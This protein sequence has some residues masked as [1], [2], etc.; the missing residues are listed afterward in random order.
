MNGV[1]SVIPDEGRDVA[2]I[3][4]QKVMAAGRNPI[5]EFTVSAKM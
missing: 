3:G 1:F 2:R 5:S 4:D